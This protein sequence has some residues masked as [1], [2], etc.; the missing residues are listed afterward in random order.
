MSC[1]GMVWIPP[2]VNQQSRVQALM[3]K[4]KNLLGASFPKIDLTIC[5]LD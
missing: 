1:S 2:S 5:E 3:S 4:K